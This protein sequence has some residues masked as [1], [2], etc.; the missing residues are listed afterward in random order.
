MPVDPST[1]PPQDPGARTAR[2]LLLR[3]GPVAKA[4]ART[5]AGGRA[6]LRMAR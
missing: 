6:A 2:G 5:A 4:V 1:P 3:G